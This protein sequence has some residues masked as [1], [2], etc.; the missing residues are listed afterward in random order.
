MR[1]ELCFKIVWI[2]QS[3]FRLSG[4]CGLEGQISEAIIRKQ[5]LDWIFFSR[6][7]FPNEKLDLW[8]CSLKIPWILYESGPLQANE[9]N[10]NL[11]STF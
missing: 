3:G 8:F 6:P 1:A 2:C 5:C 11:G 4:G 7:G 10:R 9:V